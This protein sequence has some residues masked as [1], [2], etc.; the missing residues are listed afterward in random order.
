MSARRGLTGVAVASGAAAA[1]LAALATLG[2]G[3]LSKPSFACELALGNGQIEAQIGTEG[4]VPGSSIECRDLAVVGVGFTLTRE[5]GAFGEKTAVRV[6][7]RCAALSNRDGVYTRGAIEVLDAVGGSEANVDGPFVADCPPGQIVVG[8]A[9]H[10]VG[11]GG[12]FNS[13]AIACA[14]LDPSGAPLADRA[15]LHPVL[16]TGTQPAETDAP[17]LPGSALRGVKTLGGRELDQ[18]RLVCAPPECQ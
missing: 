1:A 4:G 11:E 12:L 6:S 7:L 8:L 5:P 3:C 15:V 17:C 9:A 2:P 14:P 16:G 13:I 18:L 10:I